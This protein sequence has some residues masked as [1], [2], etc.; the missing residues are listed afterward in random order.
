MS[1]RDF[2]T[3][4]LGA[5]RFGD[6]TWGCPI[7]TSG[8][9]G[10]EDYDAEIS[11]LMEGRTPPSFGPS[12]GAISSGLSGGGYTTHSMA[13]IPTAKAMPKPSTST[14][15]PCP[16]S[17]Q[18]QANKIRK[19]QDVMKNA[20]CLRSH[21]QHAGKH[22]RQLITEWDRTILCANGIHGTCLKNSRMKS[23]RTSPLHG[24]QM[25]PSFV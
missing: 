1:P 19:I 15:R 16:T 8:E 17:Q 5:R 20:K 22:V 23:W 14:T 4:D 11:A 7:D 12:S 3:R 25:T 10:A 2:P 13:A 6:H 24:F 9:V 21:K 18:E